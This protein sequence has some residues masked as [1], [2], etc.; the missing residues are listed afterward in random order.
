MIIPISL[1]FAGRKNKKESLTRSRSEASISN[2]LIRAGETPHP[3][4]GLLK[5]AQ[6]LEQ[7]RIIPIEVYSVL[8]M[9]ATIR[10]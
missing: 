7:H 3:N 1:Q 10:N 8:E 9:L 6:W 2:V 4:D 5:K